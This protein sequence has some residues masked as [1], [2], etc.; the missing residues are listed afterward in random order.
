[1]AAS[2]RLRLF[3]GL[4][5]LAVGTGL[6]SSQRHVRGQDAPDPLTA[7]KPGL[8]PDQVVK[9]M[10]GQPSR[11]SRQIFSHQAIEQWVYDPPRSIRVTFDCHRGKKPKVQS[12]RRGFRAP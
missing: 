9:I 4:L 1:M 6:M 5:L 3:L 2:V 8:E 12:V 11:V 7:L 10:G